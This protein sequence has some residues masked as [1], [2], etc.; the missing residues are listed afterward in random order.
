MVKVVIDEVWS[1][2]PVSWYIECGT[3][4]QVVKGLPELSWRT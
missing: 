3:R 2:Y 4:V 1:V